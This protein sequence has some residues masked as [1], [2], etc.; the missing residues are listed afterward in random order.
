MFTNRPNTYFNDFSSKDAF[1]SAA[2]VFIYA[3]WSAPA[4]AAGKTLIQSLTDFPSIQLFILDNDE[5]ATLNFMIENDML[6]HGWGET[7]W[8]KNGRIISSIKRYD[9]LKIKDLVTY[10]RML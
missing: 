7:F 1:H 9:T 10:H 6:S 4:R 3:D 5:S 8:L 2:I